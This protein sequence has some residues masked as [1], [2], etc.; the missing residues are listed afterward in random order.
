MFVVL[1]VLVVQRVVGLFRAKQHQR[2]LIFFALE[3][4]FPDVVGN[5]LTEEWN[6]KSVMTGTVGAH[7][8]S[9]WAV[10]VVVD[11]NMCVK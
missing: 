1:L 8:R 11:V 6:V 2:Y 5:L 4:L 10:L 9:V 3:H 7:A